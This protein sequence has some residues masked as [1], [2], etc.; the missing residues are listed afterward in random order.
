MSRDQ[1]WELSLQLFASVQISVQFCDEIDSIIK[2]VHLSRQQSQKPRQLA[3][4]QP[5]TET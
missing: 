3:E 1:Q 4:Q 2:L 5:W